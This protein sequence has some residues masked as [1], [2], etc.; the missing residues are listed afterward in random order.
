MFRFNFAVVDHR[1]LFQK[2]KFQQFSNVCL[3][4][5]LRFLNVVYRV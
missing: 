5:F 2:I 3:T 1:A 4:K